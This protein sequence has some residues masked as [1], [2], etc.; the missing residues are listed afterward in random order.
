MSFCIFQGISHRQMVPFVSPVTIRSLSGDQAIIRLAKVNV[1]VGML[2]S[3]VLYPLQIP[4]PQ[5]PIGI[6]GGQMGAVW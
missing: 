2:R 5:A 1:L 4:D 6:P 3:L